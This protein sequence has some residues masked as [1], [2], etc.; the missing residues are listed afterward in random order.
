MG[1]RG[2]YFPGGTGYSY[3]G[4]AYGFRDR[5]GERR[6]QEDAAPYPDRA[7]CT[8]GL[9]QAGDELGAYRRPVPN[10]SQGNR[11]QVD[12][13]GI[14]CR[15]TAPNDQQGVHAGI[16]ERDE[17]PLLLPEG[18]VVLIAAFHG[19]SGRNDTGRESR[20]VGEDSKRRVLV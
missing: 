9:G 5:E 17:T 4:T 12:A 1:E 16:G 18:A 13:R 2:V 19:G 20:F 15:G 3:R 7:G 8:I 11:G 10:V 6:V 14:Q